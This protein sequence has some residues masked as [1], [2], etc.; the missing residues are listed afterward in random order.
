MH[1]RR[2]PLRI[3]RDNSVAIKQRFRRFMSCRLNARGSGKTP[4]LYLEEQTPSFFKYDQICHLFPVR[5]WYWVQF[6]EVQKKPSF[7]QCYYVTGL[8]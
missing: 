5:E 3:G 8:G 4:V 7:L 1:M 2:I 6:S